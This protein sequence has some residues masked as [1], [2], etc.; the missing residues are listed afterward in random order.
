M[1][2]MYNWNKY[3]PNINGCLE[4]YMNMLKFVKN[5]FGNKIIILFNATPMK[6]LKQECA[7]LPVSESGESGASKI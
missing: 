2:L 3:L 7:D 6:N 1:G 4:N 5:S